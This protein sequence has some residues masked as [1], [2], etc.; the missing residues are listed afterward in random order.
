MAESLP[1]VGAFH[2]RAW[3]WPAV[4]ASVSLARATVTGYLKSAETP[5]PPLEDIRLALS[6]AVTNA[7]MHAYL[8]ASAPGN[9]RVEVEFDDLQ[10]RVSV[11]DDGRGLK[12]RHD[13]PGLGL[14]LPLIATL[15]ERMETNDSPSGGTRLRMW[16]TRHPAST[17]LCNAGASIPAA[18]QTHQPPVR[19][20]TAPRADDA[21]RPPHR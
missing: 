3:T 11:E 15:A 18:R 16:F 1:P 20:Q 12:P 19:P 7:V 13:S 21:E 6:E 9:V 17:T 2:P 4:D 8:P 10:V 5:D 14:G